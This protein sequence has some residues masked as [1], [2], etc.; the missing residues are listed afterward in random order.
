MIFSYST[1]AK[2]TNANRSTSKAC[3]ALHRKAGNPVMGARCCCVIR[4]ACVVAANNQVNHV[5]LWVVAASRDVQRQACMS[6][7]NNQGEAERETLPCV[8]ALSQVLCYDE[9]KLKRPSSI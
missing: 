3:G 8:L 1:K 7:S 5:K 6:V 4:A 9:G 2:G